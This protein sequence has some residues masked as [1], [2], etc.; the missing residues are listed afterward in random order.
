[1]RYHLVTL[2][3]A[4][5]TVDS[6]RLE[7]A[8]RAG[9]HISVDTPVDADLLLVNTCGFID[10]AK[11]ESLAVVR[12]LDAERRPDQQLYVVGCLTQIAADDVRAAV[13][14]V[15]AT[16]G[17]EQWDAIAAA[18]GPAS[19]T[20]DIPDAT[21]LPQFGQPSAYLKISDGC[22]RPCTFCVIPGI[23]GGM[24]SDSTRRLL[25]EARMFAAAGAKELVLV[26]QDST[27]YG[28]DRGERD[29][30][31]TL[32]DA[33]ADAVPDVPWLR[34]MYAYPGR[35]TRTLAETMER[36]PNVVPYLDMPLQHGSNA[37]LRRMKRP[38]LRVTR[39]SLDA[40][41]TAMPDVVLRTTFIVG[42]PGESDAE[43]EELLA[44]VEREQFDH[45]G[46]FTY[47]PQAGTPAAT[48]GDQV[49]EA[50]KTERYG[51]LME[52][53]QGISH[54]RNRTVVGREL[55]VLVESTEPGQSQS[56]DPIVV[57]RTYR[58]APE[59]DGLALLKG[60]FAAGTIVRAR[61][62]GALPYDLLCDPLTD[63]PA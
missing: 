30:L 49:P 9:R 27:A 51:R 14:R 46:A 8:L 39:E 18:L 29:G 6:M 58:D 32:L 34:L 38:S 31:A 22:D 35:V 43:F 17:A 13:P 11:D 2:G 50:V 12:E 24:H 1:M 19:E 61:V 20:Y 26:A 47:S 48:M 42:F 57:G 37:V 28:E 55:D 59:V 7:Q 40:V 60:T 45:V 52:L 10:A 16:F 3:C 53:A 4:K 44:F 5:N 25:A 36:L 62:V 15:N 63:A 23:K 21:A 56:G 41:R 54:A 33:L